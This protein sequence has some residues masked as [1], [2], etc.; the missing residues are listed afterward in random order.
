M[1]RHA[2]G[3]KNVIRHLCCKT[4]SASRA[5]GSFRRRTAGLVP[6]GRK[7]FRDRHANVGLPVMKRPNRHYLS[8]QQSALPPQKAGASV[9]MAK[10]ECRS[11][12]KQPTTRAGLPPVYRGSWNKEVLADDDHEAETLAWMTR[13]NEAL[14]KSQE[15]MRQL[16]MQ[17]LKV[18]ERERKRIAADLHDGIGQSLSLIKLTMELVVQK[19]RQ[20]EHVEGMELLQQLVDR[21]R[22]TMTELHCTTACLRHSMIDNLGLLPTLKCFFSEF[23]TA[24]Q[25]NEFEKFI[26]INEGDVPTPL[27]IT[28]FRILQ[29]AMNNIAKHAGADWMRVWLG[30]LDGRLHLSIADNGKGFDRAQDSSCHD[31]EGGFGL[32]TMKE[33]ARYSNGSFEL[34][35]SPGHGTRIFISWPL[36]AEQ[37]ERPQLKARRRG[38]DMNK[39]GG[40]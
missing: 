15:E 20:G 35:S 25:G 17:L 9:A 36:V 11:A 2:Q 8:S 27:K 4:G 29:E 26:E 7:L 5:T 31:S 10:S 34:N 33:R 30:T 12:G 21:V 40:H 23:E 1:F 24:W 19:M 6:S 3:E 39:A 14:H 22:Q 18:Q 16:S 38:G 32:L 13:A 37:P 28:I